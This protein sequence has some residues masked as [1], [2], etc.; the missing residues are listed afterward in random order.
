MQVVREG[1]VHGAYGN[2]GVVPPEWGFITI[3]E[4]LW[5]AEAGL[6]I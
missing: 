3:T 2:C 1:G 5:P 6:G 4:E